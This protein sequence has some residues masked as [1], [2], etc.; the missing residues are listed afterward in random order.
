MKGKKN[1]HQNKYLVLDNS[2]KKIEYVCHLADIHIRKKDRYDEYS[3]VF[4]NLYNDIIS[5]KL[6]SDNSVIV[7]CGDI[8]NNKTELHP[9]SVSLTKDFFIA[10]CEITDVICISGNHDLAMDNS[11]MNSL[12]SIIE[13]GLKT[14]NKLFLLQNNDIYLYNN[15]I[16]GVTTMFADTVTK[17]KIDEKKIKIAL[18]H[19][20][21]EG[22]KTENGIL[23]EK[24]KDSNTRL[25]NNKDFDDYDIVML[26]DVHK[27]QFLNKD[28]TIAYSGSLIQQ[29]IDEEIDKGYLLWNINKKRASF[30]KIQNNYGIVKIV[31]EENGKSNYDSLIMPKYANIKIVSGTTNS[32]HIDK[33]WKE[34]EKSG[35]KVKNHT[36]QYLNNE[37]KFDTK[38]NINGIS[39]DLS[40]IKNKESAQNIIFEILNNRKDLSDIKKSSIKKLVEKTLKDINFVSLN[41]YKTIKLV[42]LSFDNIMIYGKSNCIDFRNFK[43]IMGITG[44]NSHGKSSIIDIILYSI[45]GEC[46]RGDRIDLINNN[47]NSFKTIIELLVNGVPIKIERI[48]RRNKKNKYSR[49]FS[50]KVQVFENNKNIS[51]DDAI[52]TNKLIYEKIVP[53]EDFMLN[54]VV[55]QGTL[56]SFCNLSSLKKRDLLYKM[57]RLDIFQTI[58]KKCEDNINFLRA[59]KRNDK[60]YINDHKHVSH[61]IY[62]LKN[63]L[64]DE[65]KKLNN[66]L[67]NKKNESI[68]QEKNIELKKNRIIELET[69]LQKNIVENIDDDHDYEHKYNE[70]CDKLK[71]VLSNISKIKKKIQDDYEMFELN[72]KK[73][74]DYSYLDVKYNKKKNLDIKIFLKDSITKLKTN[75]IGFKYDQSVDFTQK[76][77]DEQIKEKIIL[78]DKINYELKICKDKINANKKILDTEI[79]EIKYENLMKY[80]ENVEKQKN[81]LKEVELKT[82]ELQNIKLQLE[83]LNDYKYDKKCKFCMSNSLTVQKIYLSDKKENYDKIIIELIKNID[84][85]KL[86]LEKNKNIQKDYENFIELKKNKEF[87]QKELT[88]LEKEEKNLINE[89]NVINKKIEDLKIDSENIKKHEKKLECYNEIIKLDGFLDEYITLT[90]A[91]QEN[92]IKLLELEKECE[93]FETNKNELTILIEKID[94]N[95]KKI[96]ERKKSLEEL[97]NLKKELKKIE[98]VKHAD[99]IEKIHDEIC[100]AKI[101]LKLYESKIASIEEIEKECEEYKIIIDILKNSGIIDNVLNDKILPQLEN[102][103]NRLLDMFGSYNISIK[104]LNDSAKHEIFIY[105]HDNIA[106]QMDGTYANKLLDLVFRIAF[107]ETNGY[108]RTNFMIFDEIFDGADKDNRENI[109]KV[110][111]Y[112]RSN[113]D[114]LLVI[115]HDDEIKDMFD[116]ILTIKDNNNHTRLV[117][118]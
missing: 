95:N 113:F 45:F 66:I 99:E 76:Y 17:C 55:V 10:L 3:E 16:F 79:K 91:N 2:G 30:R 83:K 104:M 54:A 7:I 105:K 44:S 97:S 38:I 78:S 25:F 51:C 103:V 82:K 94:E 64:E 110:V 27:R 102:K 13:R 15:I 63:N 9:I 57:S 5:Q 117:T 50:G 22:V 90:H 96:K 47:E 35:T 19:G 116:K 88:L 72:K 56:N 18:Y 20:I 85:L 46:T 80:N 87:V 32:K 92:K 71:I 101:K 53:Y 60:K 21:I 118:Y 43:K 58:T 108:F 39:T 23:L 31:V 106:V 41:D 100:S 37:K 68:E 52:K 73:I 98:T 11:D 84:K 29:N 59:E 40:L 14:K 1:I 28:K 112:V 114:W 61:D 70:N 86:I 115:S 89:I 26:G 107:A 36:I 33:I 34:I 69:L 111:Q 42:K 67:N 12:A 4:Q 77:I 75:I 62:V 65:I 74:I 24:Y 6:D 109:K 81:N 49:V 8:L 48:G 93:T